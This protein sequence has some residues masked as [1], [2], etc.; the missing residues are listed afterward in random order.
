M[1]QL[2]CR[3][4]LG[5]FGGCILFRFVNY[6]ILFMRNL[7]SDYWSFTSSSKVS[8]LLDKHDSHAFFYESH[9]IIHSFTFPTQD[10]PATRDIMTD[11]FEHPRRQTRVSQQEIR[12]TRPKHSRLPS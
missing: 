8:V 4:E 10:T 3:R 1:S 9:C 7:Y 5:P 12:Q 2:V 11:G 6:R